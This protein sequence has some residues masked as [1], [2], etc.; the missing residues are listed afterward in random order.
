MSLRS[1]SQVSATTGRQQWSAS[2]RRSDAP[3]DQ[4]VPHRADAVGVGDGNR[5]EQEPVVVDPGRAGHLA[6]AVEAEPAGEH[7][8][9]IVPAPG[10]DRGD[11]GAHRALAL[12]RGDRCR[13]RSC[14][15]PTVTPRTSVMASSGPGVPSS[16][17]PRSRARSG[18][19]CPASR[20][21]PTVSAVTSAVAS[22]SAGHECDGPS[23]RGRRAEHEVHRA[24]DAE[25]RPRDSRA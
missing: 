2:S 19:A 1:P 9:E 18:V 17:M 10:K 12:H 25:R 13:G 4:R 7:R 23:R 3:L 11:A 14:V 5:I 21:G 20:P 24:D 6:V 22:A 16:G 15:W 8:G